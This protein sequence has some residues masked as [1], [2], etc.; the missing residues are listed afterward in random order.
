MNGNGR[1]VSWRPAWS[2]VAAAATMAAACG[3]PYGGSTNSSDS[4]HATIGPQGGQLVGAKGSA[5]D[6]ATTGLGPL[7]TRPDTSTT[8]A[9]CGP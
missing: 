9:H 3:N 6:D 2:F 7:S 5:L 8:P 4:L 1:I